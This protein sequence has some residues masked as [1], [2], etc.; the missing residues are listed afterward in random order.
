MNCEDVNALAGEYALDALAPDERAAVAAHL[1][2]CALHGEIAG[3]R[4]AALVLGA[5]AEPVAA[6]LSL[7]GRL[8]ADVAALEAARAAPDRGTPAAALTPTLDAQ[9]SAHPSPLRERVGG[10]PEARPWLPY[11]AAAM[12]AAIAIGLGAWNVTLLR[13]DRAAVRTAADVSRAAN[14]LYLS[15]QQV[16]VLRVRQL[17]ALAPERTY[18][19]W[20]IRA[21]V[22]APEGV[23]LFAVGADGAADVVL[24]T[25]LASGDTV[26]VTEEPAGG[27]PAPTSDPVVVT[28]L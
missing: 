16:A 21:G 22:S 14:L 19:V 28:K 4:A 17:P 15:D 12:F 20:V 24:D 11:A 2:T 23:A 7:R 6:P 25:P 13:D 27:S 10:R 1:E 8:L 5:S 26:A 18:Q 9:P 3:L